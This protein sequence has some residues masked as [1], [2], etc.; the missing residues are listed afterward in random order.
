[1]GS[2]GA[3][4]VAISTCTIMES[5]KPWTVESETSVRSDVF[6]LSIGNVSSMNNADVCVYCL[7]H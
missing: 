2:R 6:C 1:M 4:E 3:F 7:S 5:G